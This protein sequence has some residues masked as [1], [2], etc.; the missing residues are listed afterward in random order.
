[1]Y[2]S[3][4]CTIASYRQIIFNS[5]HSEQEMLAG[6]C[7]VTSLKTIINYINYTSIQRTFWLFFHRFVIS[8]FSI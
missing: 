3:V 4:Q 1:M 6:H 5:Y 2:R 7:N 8:R